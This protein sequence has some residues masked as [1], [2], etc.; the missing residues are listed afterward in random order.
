[1]EPICL[2]TNIGQQDSARADK[3][4][5]LLAGLYHHYADHPEPEVSKALVARI[6]KRWKDCDQPLF[7]VAL[8]LNPF[9]G[10]TRF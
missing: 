10:L 8:I 7:L 9:E 2:G 4:I 5:L 1:I 3:V 6:E